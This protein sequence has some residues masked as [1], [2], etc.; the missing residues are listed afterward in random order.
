[1]SRYQQSR[2]VRSQ[3]LVLTLLRER[4]LSDIVPWR[5]SIVGKIQF[6]K[7]L[8]CQFLIRDLHTNRF[9]QFGSWLPSQ[10][11]QSVFSGRTNYKLNQI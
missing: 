11:C 2:F 8:L 3:F 1:M 6:C 10:A 9:Q 5:E 7:S 4:F